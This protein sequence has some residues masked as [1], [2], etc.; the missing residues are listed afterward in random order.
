MAVETP[1]AE[2]GAPAEEAPAFEGLEGFWSAEQSDV[3]LSRAEEFDVEADT[4]E[5]TE[6]ERAALD[7]LLAVGEVMQRL[8]QR[9]L[10]PQ[11]EAVGVYLTAYEPTSEAE[12]GRLE[13]LR[14]LFRAASG[15]LILDLEGERVP[16]EQGELAAA[17]AHEVV[18]DQRQ[19]DVG[20]G[21]ELARQVVVVVEW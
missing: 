12:T 14:R 11:A 16:L 2:P 1:P 20:G 18:A 6:G 15:P 21:R 4:S 5:L 19:H 13:R 17:V 8:H 3:I 7:E 10:H 9:T